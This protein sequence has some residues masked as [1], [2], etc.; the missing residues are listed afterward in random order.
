MLARMLSP[1]EGRTPQSQLAARGHALFAVSTSQLFPCPR[2]AAIYSEFRTMRLLARWGLL[3]CDGVEGD[4]DD[5]GRKPT[6]QSSSA[7]SLGGV[8]AA[9]EQFQG[10]RSSWEP[11]TPSRS[12]LPQPLPM[13]LGTRSKKS[14]PAVYSTKNMRSSR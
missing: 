14:P 2:C 3:S 12:A 1:Q 8:E 11:P 5:D 13:I 4:G 9:N 10:P 6:R 7:W